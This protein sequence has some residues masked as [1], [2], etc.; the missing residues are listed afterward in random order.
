MIG[1]C[2][3]WYKHGNTVTSMSWEWHLAIGPSI[4]QWGYQYLGKNNK[5]FPIFLN[6]W[7]C[8]LFHLF[9]FIIH[10][11][12]QH[13]SQIRP[14][15][16]VPKSLLVKTQFSKYFLHRTPIASFSGQKLLK[17]IT[18]GNLCICKCTKVRILFFENSQK[19][20]LPLIYVVYMSTKKVQ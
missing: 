16:C 2:L 12:V 19:Y 5:Q 11:N 17:V 18:F 3:W 7:N 1:L 14:A 20:S 9:L 6:G 4:A 8:L 15:D 10:I 13:K